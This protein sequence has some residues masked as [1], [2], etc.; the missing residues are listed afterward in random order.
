M[1]FEGVKMRIST[2]IP[3]SS[4]EKLSKYSKMFSYLMTSFVKTYSVIENDKMTL[5]FKGNKSIVSFVLDLD[6][7]VSSPIYFSIDINKFLSAAKKIGDA[8]PLK[9]LINTAPPQI[10]IT[11]D[12]T[13]DKISFSA[14]FYETDSTE[15]SSILS[16][17]KD[18]SPLFSQGEKFNITPN[19]LDFIRITSA[20]M[21]AINKNNSIAL[22]E[23]KLVYADRTVIVNM[24]ENVWKNFLRN[25]DTDYR[26]LH[27]FVLGFMEF[28]YS[29]NNE[30][31]L[32]NN[33]SLIYWEALSD[34]N[35]WAILA[36]D[37]C[38]ISIPNRD[39]LNAII[40]EDSKVQ[41]I[42]I[43][44][45][46]LVEAIDFFSGLFEASA[47]KPITFNW[48]YNAADSTQKVILTYQ[49][50]STEVEKELIVDSFEG[51]LPEQNI[52]N[53]SFILISDSVRTLLSRM[54][55]VGTLEVRFNND[56][57]DTV[58]GAGI[59]LKYL[60][61]NNKI[62]YDAVLAK[63]QDS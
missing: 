14:T 54:L 57:T 25:S 20:Y 30:F 52:Y 15:I 38:T 18:Q 47:W 27:K 5:Y 28:V 48:T 61:T 13:N 12:A 41:K 8:L 59:Q 36:I 1:C 51:N 45:S 42:F 55:D 44:P 7:P 60:D 46:R 50:P 6:I 9:L 29:E 23:D 62:I 56:S 22:F 33:K 17:K 26:L 58:H 40:P 39:D 10:L 2:A 37:P 31:T 4:L 19:F 34:S 16:F 53:A 32:S 11:S 21:G 43:K 49:H 3:Q 24:T 63:L 35:F